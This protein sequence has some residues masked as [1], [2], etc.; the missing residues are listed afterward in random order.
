MPSSSIQGLEVQIET[1]DVEEAIFLLVSDDVGLPSDR[2]W[3]HDAA[4]DH[5]LCFEHGETEDLLG[6]ANRWMPTGDFDILN[7]EAALNAM[8]QNH[9]KSPSKFEPHS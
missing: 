6:T 1:V 8:L 2:V 5:R 4:Y 9:T 3:D 7:S